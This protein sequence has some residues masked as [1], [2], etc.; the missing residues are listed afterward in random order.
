[1]HKTTTREKKG[2]L[3]M[4]GVRKLKSDMEQV[5]LDCDRLEDMV[6]H[7]S[8][9]IVQLETAK[10]DSPPVKDTKAN[11]YDDNKFKDKDGMYNYQFYKKSLKKKEQEDNYN[12]N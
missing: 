9:K 8:K 1:M 3:N 4:L 10:S 5:K 11:A 12:G 2:D 7:L 6:I